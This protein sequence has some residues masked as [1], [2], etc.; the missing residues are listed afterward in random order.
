V[1]KKLWTSAQG[2][3]LKPTKQQITTRSSSGK[4]D[5]DDGAMCSGVFQK[6][7]MCCVTRESDHVSAVNAEK[8][9]FVFIPKCPAMS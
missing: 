2:Q 4:R 9:L 1:L 3:P 6:S 5:C 7:S 8:E